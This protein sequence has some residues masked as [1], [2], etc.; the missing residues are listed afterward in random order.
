[1]FF[2]NNNNYYQ[3][4]DRRVCAGVEPVSSVRPGSLKF[5]VRGSNQCWQRTARTVRCRLVGDDVHVSLCQQ[6]RRPSSDGELCQHA[7]HLPPL[8]V[9]HIR[10]Y[11]IVFGVSFHLLCLYNSPVFIRFILIRS[12]HT[13]L[14]KCVLINWLIPSFSSFYCP[15]FPGKSQNLIS[16]W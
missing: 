11:C 8:Y 15:K 14:Y 2:V 7:A 4:V 6:T 1:M 3:S 13:A 16:I 5:E 10:H 12:W 9:C